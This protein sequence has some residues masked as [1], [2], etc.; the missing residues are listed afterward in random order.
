LCHEK[1]GNPAVRLLQMQSSQW[2]CI[3]KGASKLHSKEP[4]EIWKRDQYNSLATGRYLLCTIDR[5]ARLGEFGPVWAI[6][7]DLFQKLNVKC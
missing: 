5:V 3:C 4:I 1:S 2:I 6:L 7:F